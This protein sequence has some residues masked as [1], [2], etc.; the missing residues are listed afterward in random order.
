M[1]SGGEAGL[2]TSERLRKGFCRQSKNI[3]TGEHEKPDR[4]I[5]GIFRLPQYASKN[6]A[7]KNSRRQK[8]EMQTRKNIQCA[9]R[10]FQSCEI[11]M[12]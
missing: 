5:I 11:H 8:T 7:R 3:N 1:G 12:K 2:K 6:Q 10:F 9:S 4:N